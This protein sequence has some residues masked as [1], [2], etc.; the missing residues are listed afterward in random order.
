MLLNVH[1]IPDEFVEAVVAAKEEHSEGKSRNTRDARDI[2]RPC[3][4]GMF[5]PR[6]RL[7]VGDCV[8]Q[9]LARGQ[10]DQPPVAATLA[11]GVEVRLHDAS[12]WHLVLVRRSED[13]PRDGKLLRLLAG[14]VRDIHAAQLVNRGVRGNVGDVAALAA[15]E[16]S[17][18][19]QHRH[20]VEDDIVAALL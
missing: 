17:L 18:P 11:P 12:A 13:A 6:R 14:T 16:V 3:Q 4:P 1:G 20:N 5:F 9:L 8:V 10:G 15:L 2:P 7:V 19:R